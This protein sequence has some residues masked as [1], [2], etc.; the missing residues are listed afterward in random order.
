MKKHIFIC[1]LIVIV[2]IFSGCSVS[3]INNMIQNQIEDMNPVVSL[4]PN[5]ALPNEEIPEELQGGKDKN[6]E[7]NTSETSQNMNEDG[8]IYATRG[9]NKIAIELKGIGETYAE[10]VKY[11]DDTGRETSNG[12]EGVYYTLN[13]IEVFE[14]YRDANLSDEGKLLNNDAYFA[15]NQFIL[16]EITANYIA[17]EG[18]EK[19]IKVSPY[20]MASYVYEKMP[21]DFLTR[22]GVENLEPIDAWFSDPPKEGDPELDPV[23]DK[24]CFMI[25]DGESFTFKFGLLAGKEFVNNGNV[26]LRVGYLSDNT[27]NAV[28]QYFELFPNENYDWALTKEEA[29]FDAGKAIAL[30]NDL[31]KS[32]KNIRIYT[33]DDMAVIK[34]IGD[35][36]PS[37]SAYKY[38][39]KQDV[40]YLGV[41]GI[42]VTLDNVTVY[43]SLDESGLTFEDLLPGIRE[44]F[45]L[46]YGFA[47]EMKDGYNE[48]YF[49]I[50]DITVEYQIY[51]N[52]P[53]EVEFYSPCSMHILP[54]KMTERQENL[55][56][57]KNSYPS[58]DYYTCEIGE[59]GYPIIKLKKGEKYSYSIGIKAGKE[60]VENDN[61]YMCVGGYSYD[62]ENSVYHLFDL[63]S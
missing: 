59:D 6:E 30:E 45:E 12:K 21:D 60:Y 24:N 2:L 44:Y 19:R 20:L 27:K 48:N 62:I 29:M 40:E 53:N 35:S 41:N 47:A 5:E 54:E 15:Q 16:L 52:C 18:G 28:H 31:Y 39:N 63:L 42:Y 9:E 8:I 49:I 55:D 17:P 58:I 7:L 25:N 56:A 3:S 23:H 38:E 26:F 33:P 32:A 13:S 37:F 14:N 10:L 51:N 57:F 4:K 36:L 11:K 1:L 34:N 22:V 61:V 50:A 43:S 46:D